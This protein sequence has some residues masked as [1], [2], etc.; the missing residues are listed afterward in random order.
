MNDN[1]AQTAVSSVTAGTSA[2]LI[3]GDSTLVVL[4]SGAVLLVDTIILLIRKWRAK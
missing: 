1:I 2:G 3:S 4:V